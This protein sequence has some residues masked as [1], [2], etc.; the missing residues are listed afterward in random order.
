MSPNNHLLVV[1][2]LPF[3]APK[4]QQADRQ[5]VQP[6]HP[7]GSK[8]IKFTEDRRHSLKRSPVGFSHTRERNLQYYSSVLK[9][10]PYGE[11]QQT[12]EKLHWCSV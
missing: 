4:H 6:T 2:L 12:A 9:V 11:F 10:E 5:H 1:F 3:Q 8:S 7:F